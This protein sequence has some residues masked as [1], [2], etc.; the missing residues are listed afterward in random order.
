[1]VSA[2]CQQAL[3]ANHIQLGQSRSKG[4]SLSG[5]LQ[6]RGDGLVVVN[7]PAQADQ[8]LGQIP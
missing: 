5:D 6:E 1:M 7:R 8:R 2:N 3:K 4:N